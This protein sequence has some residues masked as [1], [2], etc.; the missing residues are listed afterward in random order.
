MFSHAEGTKIA[1]KDDKDLTK[2]YE[3]RKQRNKSK[4]TG[5]T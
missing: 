4:Y 2:E 3:I 1:W 5:Q